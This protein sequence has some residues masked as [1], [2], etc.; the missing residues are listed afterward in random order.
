MRFIQSFI[1]VVFIS[2][3]LQC[4]E[5]QS[6]LKQKNIQLYDTFTHV[7]DII[8]GMWRPM[9]GSEQVAWISPPWESEEYVWFDFPETIWV[10]GEIAY[11]GHIDKRFPTLFPDLKSVAWTK[12]STGIS[13][14]QQLPNGLKFGGDI[15]RL[16]AQVTQLKLWVLN[17]SNKRLKDIKLQTCVFLNGIKE[18]NERTNDN[19]FIHLPNE[20]WVPFPDASNDE[21]LVNGF[22]V[23]WLAGTPIADLPVIVVKSNQENRL[24]ALTWFED[25]FSFIGNEA[26][27]CVHADP[28]MRDLQPEESQTINGELIFF[29][30][31]LEEFELFFRERMKF[32]EEN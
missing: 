25:T 3:N 31:S 28:V 32:H 16:N 5:I 29:E 23:G 21:E 4:Q 1:I 7:T 24:L 30:G 20:G 8:P 19:K 22:R 17:D 9:F 12:T 13:Y 14:Q 27:P 18:F 15:S 10:A 11:L 6:E 26:H 2:I